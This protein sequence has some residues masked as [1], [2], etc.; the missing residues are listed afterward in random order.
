MFRK[1]LITHS[2]EKCMESRIIKIKTY[3]SNIIIVPAEVKLRV[4][5]PK[6]PK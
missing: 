3:K 5:K 4:F 6:G 2:A 1:D